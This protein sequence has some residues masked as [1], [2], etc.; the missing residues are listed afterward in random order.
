[1]NPLEALTSRFD[2]LSPRERALVAACLLCVAGFAAAKWGILPAR[3][4]YQRNRE[5]IPPRLA[6]IARYEAIRQGQE[7]IDEE[8]FLQLQQLEKWEDGLLVGETASAAGVFLQGLLKPLTQ[9]PDTRVTSIRGLTPV[10]KGAY[11]EVAV[12]LEIQTSTEGLALLLADIARQPRILRVRKLTAN[13]GA[14][15]AHPMQRKEVVAVSMVVAGLST[16]PVD[17][18]AAGGGEE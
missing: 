1:M 3:A 13:A 7:R 17:E 10:R 5:A 9:G 11:T 15:Y 16:A 14:Y 4:E 2:A 8:L 18:N 6:T 12:Q